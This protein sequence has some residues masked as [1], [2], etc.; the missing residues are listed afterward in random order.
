MSLDVLLVE[1]WAAEPRYKLIGDNIGIACLKAILDANTDLATGML[2]SQRLYFGSATSD[3]PL[4]AIAD[5]ASYYYALNPRLVLGISATSWRLPELEDLVTRVRVRHPGMPIMA[6]GYGPTFAPDIALSFGVS[7]VCIGEGDATVIELVR[8]LRGEKE[9]PQVDGIAYCESDKLVLTNTRQLIDVRK[10]PPPSLDYLNGRTLDRAEYTY[11]NRGCPHRC[12][13]CFIHRFYRKGTGPV[14]RP[15]KAEQ[16]YVEFRARKLLNPK[17]QVILLGDDNFLVIPSL[18]SGLRTLLKNDPLTSDLQ[19]EFGVGAH[20]LNDN[21]HAIEDCMDIIYKIEL[22]Y[23]SR[24]AA[25]LSRQKKGPSLL[26]MARENLEAVKRLQA[27]R[28][29]HRQ[30]DYA[31]FHI[32]GDRHTTVEELREIYPEGEDIDRVEWA[33]KILRSGPNVVMYFD[34]RDAS[35]PLYMRAYSYYFGH[36][37]RFAEFLAWIADNAEGQ[38]RKLLEQVLASAFAHA[39]DVAA[40]AYERHQGKRGQYLMLDEDLRRHIQTLCQSEVFHLHQFCAS[41]VIDLAESLLLELPLDELLAKPWLQGYARRLLDRFNDADGLSVPPYVRLFALI[42]AKYEEFSIPLTRMA[43]T[44]PDFRREYL[45]R[46]YNRILVRLIHNVANFA[47]SSSPC[48]LD[49]SAVDIIQEASGLLDEL[50]HQLMNRFPLK[51]PF[52]S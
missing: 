38:R 43:K 28:A 20:E 18:L 13:F 25:F 8:A 21:W 12:S 46:V 14:W 32:L 45:P 16:L 39:S 33:V 36:L 10:L 44:Y 2:N 48:W 15:K 4:E 5:Y 26:D 9:L 34:E 35:Y 50:L 17:L 37:C 7:A 24:V 22:G 47:T 27:A 30:F 19:I 51:D 3:N 11:A 41:Y 23:E 1:L 31:L 49:S 42:F 40:A 52:Q 6:G 29:R